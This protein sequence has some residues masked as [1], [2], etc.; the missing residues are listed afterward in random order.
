MALRRITGDI[1]VPVDADGKM[2][3][4]LEG[5][6]VGLQNHIRAFK[7]KAVKINPGLA[8]EE[9]TISFTTHICH[10]DTGGKCEPEVEI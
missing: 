5:M 3:S 9:A 10:H 4:G 6:W 7:G 2:D 8:N 1:A